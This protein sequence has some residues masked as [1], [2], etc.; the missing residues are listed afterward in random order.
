VKWLTFKV[1]HEKGFR[2]NLT[3]LIFILFLAGLCAVIQLT[4]HDFRISFIPAYL[5]L[6]FFMFCNIFRI[7]NKLEVFWY[8]PFV[9]VC[10]YCLHDLNINLFWLLCLLILE[11]IK[12]ILIT[13]NYLKGPYAGISFQRILKNR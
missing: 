3:D 11:P 13:Y 7:G 6:S 4:V 1:Q 10:A 9:M 5:A 12:W 8:L 2:F